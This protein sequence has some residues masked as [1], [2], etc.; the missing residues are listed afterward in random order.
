MKKTRKFR[1]Y[2]ADCFKSFEDD[3]AQRAAQMLIDHKSQCVK[4][5]TTK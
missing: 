5:E 4:K 2:C 1:D 3:D